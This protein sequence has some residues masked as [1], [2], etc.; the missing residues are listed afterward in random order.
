MRNRVDQEFDRE[1]LEEPVT[2]SKIRPKFKWQEKQLKR[3]EKL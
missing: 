3:K 1:M 2:A